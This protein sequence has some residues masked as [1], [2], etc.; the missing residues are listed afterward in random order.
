MDGILFPTT[1]P[2]R[3]WVE[4]PARGF[5][6]AVAGVMH[7]GSRP[8]VCGMPLGG[9]DTGCLDIEPTGLYGYSSIFNCH[10]CR[11]GPINLPFMGLTVG[12]RTWLLTTV[13]LRARRDEVALKPTYYRDSMTHLHNVRADILKA[14]EIYYWGHYPIADMEVE[15]GAP[16]QVALRTWSPFVPGDVELSNTPGSVFE[17]HLQNGSD[18]EQTGTLAFSFPGPNEAEA[19]TTC[20]SRQEGGPIRN[21][22]CVRSGKADYVLAVMGEDPVRIG[23]DLGTD[24]GAWGHISEALPYAKQQAGSSIAVDFALAPGERK[25]VRFLL[26]WYSPDWKGG[27]TPDRGGG[28]YTHMYAARYE[29]AEAVAQFLAASHEQILQRILSW[30][31]V[32]LSEPELPVWL[33]S[34]L[35][36]YLHLI[37]ENSLW[38]Q[39]KE[40][41]GNWCRQED[42]LFGMIE[43]ARWAPQ[44]E[45]IP[46]SFYGNLPLVYFFPELALSTLRGYKAYQYPDGQVPWIFGGKSCGT[47]FI[48]MATPGRG[49]SE[50]PQA[51]LDG[52]CYVDMVDRMWMRT[53]DRE[54]LAEFY[55]S[56][57]SNTIFTMNLRP[58][59]G[60]AGVVSMPADNNGSDWMEFTDFYGIVPHIGGVHLAQLRMA[61]RMAERVGDQAFAAQ[62]REWLEAG[63]DVMDEH[64]W[65]GDYYMLYHEVESGKQSRWIMG[66]QLDG[67]WMA[68]FHGLDGAFRPDRVRITL[69]T[70]DRTSVA[71]GCGD[72]SVVFL[73]PPADA[74][75]EEAQWDT[76]YWLDRGIH[77][78]GTLILGMTYMYNG[79]REDGMELARQVA[80]AVMAQGW[81]WDLPV[82][83]EGNTRARQGGFDYY[84]N[85]MLWSLPAVMEGGDLA[86][87][88]KPGGLVDRILQ[89]G[90]R[91]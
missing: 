54:V 10:V 65:A 81:T 88:C 45:C 56:V 73:P 25:V 79:R 71:E 44:V 6:K 18:E 23:G 13:D 15:I 91:S 16:V 32:I 74:T 61:G 9:I 51:T 39:A 53:G 29:S 46:C 49:Y 22:I 30:Q 42:G 17:V 1:L 47:P 58:G 72:G 89:A 62:C 34:D 28:T 43:S 2:E 55:E 76:G 33:R 82:V 14:E 36:N 86:G 80:T 70:L 83:L 63:R 27:G 21:G 38:A 12:R 8:P 77:I 57:K 48:E 26:T 52:A 5:E 68:R 87:P 69:A 37:T 41:V 66:S 24:A 19:G 64:A 60:A 4:F 31:A 20:L 40:P 50:K 67:E 11:R 35:V 85:L 84:Q 78:P 7:R 75:A 90:T 3:S 59:S